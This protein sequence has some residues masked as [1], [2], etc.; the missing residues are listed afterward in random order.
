M[1]TEQL[2]WGFLRSHAVNI[3]RLALLQAK[4]KEHQD[5]SC[6][7]E[8]QRGVQNVLFLQG[9]C[10]KKLSVEGAHLK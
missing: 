8:R 1:V 2:S 7:R 10:L 9:G 6:T 4:E 3:C 5:L